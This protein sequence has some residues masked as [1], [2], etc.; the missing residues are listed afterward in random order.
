MNDS[1][2]NFIR[3]YQDAY[4]QEFGKYYDS[5][6]STTTDFAHRAG[7]RAVAAHGRA[8][9]R[10]LSEQLAIVRQLRKH[11]R[12]VWAAKVVENEKLRDLADQ[13]LLE[14]VKYRKAMRELRERIKENGYGESGMYVLANNAIN[15][16]VFR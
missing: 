11:E 10:T 12:E 5:P 15:A 3:V 14:I 6:R 13:R 16:E 7:L 9:G 1:D 8:S 4:A 2:E